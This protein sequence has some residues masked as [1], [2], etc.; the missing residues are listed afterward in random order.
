MP[1]K[2]PKPNLKSAHK[3]TALKTRST[4]N[5][6]AKKWNTIM[7]NLKKKYL[8]LTIKQLRK[9]K[10]INHVKKPH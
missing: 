10:L 3:E 6:A 2:T 8:L 9:T 7:T 1:P 4:K 5:V